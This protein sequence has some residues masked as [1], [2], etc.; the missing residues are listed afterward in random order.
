MCSFFD[1]LIIIAIPREMGRHKAEGYYSTTDVETEREGGRQMMQEPRHE[2]GAVI[3]L[4]YR[5]H[6]GS[7]TAVSIA[8]RVGIQSCLRVQNIIAPPELQE[9]I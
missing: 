9:A 8:L 5:Y 7:A 2:R 3:S 1:L 4:Q 6:H